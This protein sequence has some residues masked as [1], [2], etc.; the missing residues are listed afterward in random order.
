VNASRYPQ[1]ADVVRQDEYGRLLP[2]VK[3]LL[4][5]PH[6]VVLVFLGIAAMLA[7]LVSFFAVPFT[8]SYP[9]GLFER[10]P[11]REPRGG[12]RYSPRTL[13]TRRLGRR[14]SNST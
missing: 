6:Y 9:R 1:R 14:P 2:L 4:A 10:L 11:T 7:V 12:T 8:R 13:M 3:W 5:F